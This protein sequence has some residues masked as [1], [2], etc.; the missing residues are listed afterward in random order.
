MIVTVLRPCSIKSPI[1]PAHFGL[2]VYIVAK[3]SQ[4]KSQLAI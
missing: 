3:M 1:K 2:R 4:L